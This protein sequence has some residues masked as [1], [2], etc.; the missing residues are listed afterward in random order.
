MS[1][2]VLSSLVLNGLVSRGIAEMSKNG[3]LRSLFVNCWDDAIERLRLMKQT[4]EE[5][6]TY[7]TRSISRFDGEKKNASFL[8]AF[9]LFSVK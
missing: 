5:V 3:S 2:A 8:I 6:V 7:R 9:K 4:R 1:R